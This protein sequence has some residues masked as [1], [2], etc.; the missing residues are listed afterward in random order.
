[1]EQKIDIAPEL[2]RAAHNLE[3]RFDI[4]RV[5]SKKIPIS[6]W[7]A[8]PGDTRTLI[9][10][11]LPKLLSTYSIAG[12]WLRFDSRRW[13]RDWDLLG[14]LWPE[15]YVT[16]LSDDSPV[17]DIIGYGFFPFARNEA[18]GSLWV[19]TLKEGPSGKIYF[20]DHSCWDGGKPTK[21]NGLDYA[22]SSLAALIA[23][24]TIIE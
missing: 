21:E 7:E 12:I 14:F 20:I 17:L 15:E 5:Q 10:E 23:S 4:L 19:T 13:N 24:L 8:L 6:Y 2:A 11:W 16:Y 3:E 22:H 9:P 18:N 1:M